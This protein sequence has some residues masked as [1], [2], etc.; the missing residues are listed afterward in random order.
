MPGPQV[1]TALEQPKLTKDF[2]LF[3]KEMIVT[4]VKRASIKY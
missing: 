2:F 3:P 1:I 4:L